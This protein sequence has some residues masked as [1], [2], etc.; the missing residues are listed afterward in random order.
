MEDKKK[1]KNR[2]NDEENMDLITVTNSFSL[3]HAI[4]FLLEGCSQCLLILQ[5]EVGRP[6]WPRRRPEPMNGK[7]VVPK[8]NHPF[9]F[10]VCIHSLC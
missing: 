10:K 2:D 7:E 6:F 8:R 5:R 4:C 9:S 1:L 3:T